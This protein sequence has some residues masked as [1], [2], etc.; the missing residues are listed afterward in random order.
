MRIERARRGVRRACQGFW[1]RGVISWAVTVLLGLTILGFVEHAADAQDSRWVFAFEPVVAAGLLDDM[2]CDPAP[3]PA[4]PHVDPASWS[5]RF[6]SGLLATASDRIAG[7][8]IAGSPNGNSFDPSPSLDAA[9]RD[10]G[11]VPLVLRS[12]DDVLELRATDAGRSVEP[13][14][15]LG[16]SS[17]A[18][19]ASILV[20][21]TLA[22]LHWRIVE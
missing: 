15:T 4:S 21:A 19:L 17:L 22:L 6:G 18:V 7:G 5:S 1:I 2:I 8:N 20:V 9:I 14:P 13:I 10:G 3:V 11:R 16:E 12:L